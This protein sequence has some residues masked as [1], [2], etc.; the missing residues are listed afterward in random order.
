[1]QP[2]VVCVHNITH[3]FALGSICYCM[4]VSTLNLFEVEAAVLP[5]TLVT[6]LIYL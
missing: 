3:K 6:L 2:S 1:M 5:W 4:F